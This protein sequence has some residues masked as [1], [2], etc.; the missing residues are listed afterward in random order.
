MFGGC[1]SDQLPIPATATT[2]VPKYSEAAVLRLVAESVCPRQPS[3]VQL[4]LSDKL[5]A[6]YEGLGSWNVHGTVYKQGKT[7][8]MSWQVDERS[9][10]AAPK[11]DA[12][13]AIETVLQSKGRC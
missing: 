11:R 10:V 5:S 3:L 12:A 13:L 7:Y 4:A 6:T 2:D 8:E 1:G 9:G